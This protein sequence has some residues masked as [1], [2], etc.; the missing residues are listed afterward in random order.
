M[1]AEFTRRPQIDGFPFWTAL[2]SSGSMFFRTPVLSYNL[3]CADNIL[4][5]LGQLFRW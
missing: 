4:I 3:N 5:K 2:D 1:I